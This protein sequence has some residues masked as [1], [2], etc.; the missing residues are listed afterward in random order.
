MLCSARA[1]PLHL[2]CRCRHQGGWRLPARRGERVGDGERACGL[3]AADGA[4]GRWLHGRGDA[5]ERAG[6][7][8]ALDGDQ[9]LRLQRLREP[10]QRG[11]PRVL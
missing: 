9:R 6:A 10:E 1:A 4:Y 7:G 11:R 5:H 2:G 8:A 3:C